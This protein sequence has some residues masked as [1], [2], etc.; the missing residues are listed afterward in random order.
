MIVCF[1][2]HTISLRVGEGHTTA[3]IDVVSIGCA[4]GG[5]GIGIDVCLDDNFS[6]SDESLANLLGLILPL[7]KGDRELV[8]ID[9]K[10]FAAVVVR[11]L[12]PSDS[13]GLNLCHERLGC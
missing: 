3:G 6:F 2:D 1:H 5:E 10:S 13:N 9:E 8:T 12:V 4:P 11:F 7:Q